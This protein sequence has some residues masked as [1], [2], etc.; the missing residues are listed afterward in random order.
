MDYCKVSRGK[1]READGGEEGGRPGNR[2]KG[3]GEG[4]ASLGV[5]RD[6]PHRTGEAGGG[7][8]GTWELHAAAP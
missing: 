8:G 3:G 1:E 5:S 7:D 4:V 6:P 2:R